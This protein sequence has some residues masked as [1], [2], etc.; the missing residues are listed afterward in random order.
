MKRKSIEEIVEPKQK[1]PHITYKKMELDI[2]ERQGKLD[3][4]NSANNLDGK[5][6]ESMEE[7]LPNYNGFAWGICGSAGQGNT[8][9]PRTLVSCK[10]VYSC[11][12]L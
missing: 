9:R 3:V 4:I 12:I 11:E 5:L 7:P 6:T 8:K 10:Q 1:K 2:S